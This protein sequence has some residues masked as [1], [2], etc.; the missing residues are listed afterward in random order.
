LFDLA[1]SLLSAS[2]TV[3]GLTS[4]MRASSGIDGSF[5]PTTK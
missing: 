2:R 4:S 1:D 5:W 3:V